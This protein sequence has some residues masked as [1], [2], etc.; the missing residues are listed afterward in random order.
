MLFLGE[1]QCSLTADAFS[2]EQVEI[3]QNSEIT[4]S[5]CC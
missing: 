5:V 2:P 4:V 3:L 1:P